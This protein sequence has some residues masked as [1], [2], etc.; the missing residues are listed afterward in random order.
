MSP[1]AA[2][3]RALWSINDSG[4]PILVALDAHGKTTARVPIAGARVEDWEAMAIGACPSGSCLFIADIG[5]NTARRSR[6]TIYRLQEPDNAATSTSPV[7]TFHATYPDGPHDAETILVGPSGR[8][9]IVTKGETGPVALYAFPA[10]L[11]ANT[12]NRLE[13]IGAGRAEGRVQAGE[14]ITDGAVSPDG[15]WVALRTLTT[16]HLHR[17]AD[18]FAGNWKTSHRVDLTPIREPQGEGVSFVNETTLVLA[19]E[20]ESR[21]EPGTL[22]YLKCTLD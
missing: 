17:A 8:L 16:L 3:V 21:S 15:R 18:L 22:A 11:H 13:K 12:A 19:G 10:E 6:I 1:S 14:R 20:G 5:D 9:F 7:E 2:A 4:A